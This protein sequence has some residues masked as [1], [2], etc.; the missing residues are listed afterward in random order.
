[1]GGGWGPWW[2]G[3]RVHAA[4][5]PLPPR[6][7]SP[8]TSPPTPPAHRP[9]RTEAPPKV[10]GHDIRTGPGGCGGRAGVGRGGRAARSAA[11]RRGTLGCPWLRR[12]ARASHPRLGRRCF[13]MVGISRI[14]SLESGGGRA[15]AGAGVNG[16]PGRCAWAIGGGRSEVGAGRSPRHMCASP[17]PPPRQTAP[18][19]R[20]PPGGATENVVSVRSSG[21]DR[22]GRGP[23]GRGGCAGFGACEWARCAG[24]GASRVAGRI[25]AAQAGRAGQA[26]VWGGA[27][28]AHWSGRGRRPP[29][30]APG[31][32][33]RRPCADL[34]RWTIPAQ[35]A[36]RSTAALQV[37]RLHRHNPA[38]SLTDPLRP[39]PPSR[40]HPQTGHTV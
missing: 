13:R 21:L 36:N 15:A 30:P 5:P 37:P 29:A 39:D 32:S 35:K 24:A 7:P 3:R 40:S 19:P 17:P 16:G 18:P 31:R 14:S 4:W 28:A 27:W 12:P 2:A 20:H 33:L 38:L 23:R 22:G 11:G 34:P 8:L 6:S 26:A 9:E 25:A 10:V 1:M